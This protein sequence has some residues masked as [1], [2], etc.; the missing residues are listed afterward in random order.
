M[1]ALKREIVEIWLKKDFYYIANKLGFI[2]K[3]YDISLS[4][5][6]KSIRCLDYITTME[7][8]N[9]NY[10]ITI[11][12]LMWTHIDKELYDIRSLVIKYLS[13]IGYQHQLSLWM[14]DLIKIQ[15]HFL[16]LAAQWTS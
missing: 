2:K 7:K 14:M 1:E 6:I 10:V 8:H 4:Q 9:A 13:R 5:I 3:D 16:L 12:A 15:I 11:L